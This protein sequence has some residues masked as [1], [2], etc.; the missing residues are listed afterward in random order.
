MFNKFI[1]EYDKNKKKWET[2]KSGKKY[3]VGNTTKYEFIS[4]GKYNIEITNNLISLENKGA[5]NFL[6][7]GAIGSK[8]IKIENISNRKRA[9][10]ERILEL[11]DRYNSLKYDNLYQINRDE[12]FSEISKLCNREYDLSCNLCYLNDEVESLEYEYCNLN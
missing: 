6:N 8:T 1:E 7:K 5:Q 11:K 10:E 4:N 2:K 12:L 3:V 9:L